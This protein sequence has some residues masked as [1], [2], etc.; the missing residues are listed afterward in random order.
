[1]I[2]NIGETVSKARSLRNMRLPWMAQRSTLNGNGNGVD[3]TRTLVAVSHRNSSGGE[4]FRTLRT[5]LA[6]SRVSGK[7]RSLVVTSASPGEGK[8][9][10][11]A[12]L[13]ISFAQNGLRV[14]LIDGDLRRPRVAQLFGLRKEPGLT[15]LIMGEAS[16]EEITQSTWIE[17]LYVITSG[18]IPP[19]PAELLS[20]ARMAEVM[21]ELQDTF[22]LVIVDSPP[23]LAAA[24]SAILGRLSDG[25][26]LVVRAGRTDRGAARQSLSQLRT[27]GARVLGGVLNDP[28]SLLESYGA[29]YSGYYAYDYYGDSQGSQEMS[30]T[31]SVKV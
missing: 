25:V 10:V 15:G 17:N 14:L 1:V 29:H 22:D 13:S 24:D 18:A 21:E 11:A 27:V 23:V 6:F 7:I 28:E 12:N 26:L 8:S 20:T 2:P 16:R 4:S 30:G 5:N 3:P 19:N 9:T 31:K